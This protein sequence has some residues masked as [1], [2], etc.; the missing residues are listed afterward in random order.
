MKLKLLNRSNVIL[1]LLIFIVIVSMCLYHYNQNN[2][3]EGFANELKSAD[4]IENELTAKYSKNL[5]GKSN[6]DLR[7]MVSRL[8]LRLNR[9]G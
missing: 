7:K 3:V 8:R 5:S 2:A 4:E 6:E 9:Y 1:V